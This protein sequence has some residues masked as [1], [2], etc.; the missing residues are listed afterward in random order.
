MPGHVS[1]EEVQRSLATVLAPELLMEVACAANRAVVDPDVDPFK[2][3]SRARALL[4]AFAVL[5]YPDHPPPLS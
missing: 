3:S 5:T 1:Y 2:A 4:R